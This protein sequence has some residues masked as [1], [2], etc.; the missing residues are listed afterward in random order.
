MLIALLA[1][2]GVN[3]VVIV[4]LLA[5]ALG[6]KRWVTSQAGA[7]RAAARGVSGGAH[8]FHPKW[9]RGYGRWVRGVLVWTRAPFFF[10]NEILPVDS[11]AEERPAEPGEVSRLGDEA[12][13]VRLVSG[14]ATVEV[15]ARRGDR[16]LL[17]GPYDGS[18]APVPVQGSGP[19]PE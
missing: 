14:V 17:V 10:W 11:V 4:V 7:F 18:V 2:L 16:A 19:S 8:G 15:A 5:V 12:I 6:R 1:V 9:R 3:L 13:V